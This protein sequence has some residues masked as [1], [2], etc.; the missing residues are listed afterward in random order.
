MVTAELQWRIQASLRFPLL[1]SNVRGAWIKIIPDTF[2]INVNNLAKKEMGLYS[3][4]IF[5]QRAGGGIN[6]VF[7][8]F[9]LHLT[10][11]ESDVAI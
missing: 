2:S 7:Q 5:F 11:G 9:Y 3:E 1:G 10:D 4:H 6:S 8:F